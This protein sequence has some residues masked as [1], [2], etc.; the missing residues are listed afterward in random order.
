M[1]FFRKL[2]NELLTKNKIGKY[3]AYAIGEIMLVV[4]GILIALTVNN[5]SNKKQK[6]QQT[7]RTAQNVL[8]QIELDTTEISNVFR[9]WVIIQEQLKEVLS[10]TSTDETGACDYCPNLILNASLPNLGDDVIRIIEADDPDVSRLGDVL[11][12][13]SKKYKG[14]YQAVLIYDKITTDAL[15]ENLKY[16]RD[17]KNWFADLVA[18]NVCNDECKD[19]FV[20]STDYKNRAAYMDLVLYDAYSTELYSFKQAIRKDMKLL[21]E[22]VKE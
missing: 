15:E 9:N 20:K 19:Y 22:L 18:N 4:I 10:Q 13:I 14:L 11:Q 8:R 7:R 6:E 3:L 16:L 12:E 2:R 5:Y 1:R 21:T 17:N